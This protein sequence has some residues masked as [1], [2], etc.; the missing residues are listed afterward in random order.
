[1]C[2]SRTANAS[3]VHPIRSY[4]TRSAL[5]PSCTILQAA[6]AC[7]AFP[8]TF[9]PVAVGVGHK[10]VVLIDAMA[11]CANPAKELLQE[12]QELFG[13]DMEVA[14]IISIGAGKGNVKAEFKA[15]R[16]PGISER[17]R[18]GIAMCEQVHNDLYGRLQE[19]KIYYRFNMEREL[20][21]HPEDVFAHVSAYLEEKPTSAMIDSAVKS[22]HRL[23]NGVKLKDISE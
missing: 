6:C 9:E 2:T 10:K 12:A 20:S 22:I 13:E 1:V 7:I 14:T 16:E 3:L 23:P 4:P 18:T 21:I 11:V 5:S 19:T 8:D 15:G 17:L